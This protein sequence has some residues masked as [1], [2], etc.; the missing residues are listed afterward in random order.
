MLS[1]LDIPSCVPCL[2]SPCCL[3]NGYIAWKKC[4]MCT[5]ADMVLAI[6]WWE[7][8]PMLRGKSLGNLG[9]FGTFGC[10][11]HESGRNNESMVKGEIVKETFSYQVPSSRK[12]SLVIC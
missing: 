11:D 7:R 5:A 2:E 12:D 10:N 4:D 9:G 8:L 3:L 6:V 1:E